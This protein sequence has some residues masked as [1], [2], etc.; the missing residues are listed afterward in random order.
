MTPDDAIARYKDKIPAAIKRV[1]ALSADRFCSD[2][3]YLGVLRMSGLAFLLLML[4]HSVHHRGQLSTYLRAMGGRVP[5]IYGPS[6]NSQMT[7]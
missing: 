7:V 6:A 2:I 3:D 5:D 1:R 4:K